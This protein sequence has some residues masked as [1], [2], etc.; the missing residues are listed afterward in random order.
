MTKV[1]KT[2]KQTPVV[3]M[4]PLTSEQECKFIRPQTAR[5]D[6]CKGSSSHTLSSLKKG[7]KAE[8]PVEF[9]NQNTCYI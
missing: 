9:D 1:K 3:F 7:E 5:R 6:R 8:K 4:T 2:S